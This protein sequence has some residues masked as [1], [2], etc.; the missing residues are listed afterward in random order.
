MFQEVTGAH[1]VI[2]RQTTITIETGG[3]QCVRIT[4]L[5]ELQL[6]RS[7]ATEREK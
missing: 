4:K 2:V 1:Y 5:S 7:R 6:L 3:A